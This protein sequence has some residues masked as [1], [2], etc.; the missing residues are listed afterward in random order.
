MS[1]IRIDPEIQALIPPLSNEE[2]YQLKD[3]IEAD[4]LREAIILWNGIVIDGH[5]RKKIC[6]ELGIEVRTISKEFENRWDV[7][8][9]VIN[10]QFGR[11]NLTTFQKA[12]LALKY[13]PIIA[14]RAKEN[15]GMRTDIPQNSA[16]SLTPVDTRA[17]L[18]TKAGISH[19]TIHK[20]KIIIE[21]ADEETKQKLRT[22]ASDMSINKAHKEIKRKEKEKT[23][24]QKREQR[25]EQ[26]ATAKT[27][28]F[29]L[30]CKDIQDI[31]SD[32]IG[33]IDMIITDPPYPEDY[34]YLYPILGRK[35][36]ELL[37][38]GG[39]LIV[40]I[41]QS[42]LPTIIT[43]LSEHLTF[44]WILSYLTPGGQS[45]QLWQ[46]KVNTFWKPLLWFTKGDYKGKWIGDVAKDT[47]NDNDKDW[48]HWGQ[49]VSGMVDIVNRFVEPGQIILDP[50]CGAGTTGIATIKSGCNFIGVDNDKDQI[51]I[52]ASRLGEEDGRE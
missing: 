34:L 21:Q 9:W 15:Q 8:E 47:V 22:G 33:H 44:Q 26:N 36:F 3:N 18:A 42:Y 23:Q 5:H 49:S 12:E 6:D 19:D 38:E 46:R 41:G 29:N 7:L 43:A 31:T 16:K 39:S 2:Y 45:V 32:E 28:K 20:T 4:G 52:S 11:R 17:E 48:H 40:M 37:P 51:K 14:A 35:A 1:E 25:I 50:F 24:E 30:I 27:N 13:E 10:N